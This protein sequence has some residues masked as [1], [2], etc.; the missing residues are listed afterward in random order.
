MC[1][2]INLLTY[3]P[4]YT[5]LLTSMRSTPHCCSLPSHFRQSYKPSP[6]HRL[7]GGDAFRRRINNSTEC[8]DTL[9]RSGRSPET[10]CNIEGNAP[11]PAGR[12]PTERQ[13]HTYATR[14]LSSV[15][16]SRPLRKESQRMVEPTA[17]LSASPPH[18]AVS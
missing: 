17:R 14:R 7:R 18:L 9:N 4:T 2:I 5:Y 3:L 6:R 13:A 1:L 16:E 11:R 10:A 8:E 12:P 15:T